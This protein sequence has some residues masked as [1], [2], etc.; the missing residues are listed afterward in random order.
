MNEVEKTFEIY[1]I[2]ISDEHYHRQM[3]QS[4]LSYHTNITL[5]LLTAIGAGYLNAKQPVHFL[6]IAFFS[7]LFSALCFH[8]IISVKRIYDH[9]IEMLGVREY[10]EYELGLRDPNSLENKPSNT[11]DS[12]KLWNKAY[13][14]TKPW[15]A[16]RKR[17]GYFARM[18]LLFW[19]LFFI[20]IL[21]VLVS[22]LIYLCPDKAKFIK[23]SSHKT[24]FVLNKNQKT[25]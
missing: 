17:K 11:N 16:T 8:S 14:Y 1:K 20:G 21:S 2:A 9:F 23:F 19:S 6:I 24:E 5:A 25:L 22:S 7:A 4:R 3:F 10:L 15:A 13:L 18:K 12:E